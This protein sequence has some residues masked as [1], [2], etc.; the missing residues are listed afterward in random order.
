MAT[1][2]GNTLCVWDT[3]SGRARQMN[4]QDDDLEGTFAPTWKAEKPLFSACNHQKAIT[5][6]TYNSSGSRLLT[7]ALDQFVKVYSTT[8]YAVV[9]SFPYPAPVQAVALSPDDRDLVVG[10]ADGKV[11]INARPIGA[12]RAAPK[13][14]LFES[15]GGALF[16]IPPQHKWRRSIN[17]H[18]DENDIKLEGKHSKRME[19]YDYHFRKF[20]YHKALDQALNYHKRNENDPDEDSRLAVL[21]VLEELF[22]RNGLRIALH[23]RTD[24]SLLPILKFIDLHI[25]DPRSCSLLVSVLEVIIEIYAGVIKQS[26]KVELLMQS[27]LNKVRK[28]VAHLQQMAMVDGMLDCMR[29]ACEAQSARR[30]QLQEAD[31]GTETES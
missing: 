6:L 21:S 12:Q 18:A 27:C 29:I 10:M 28:H 23:G 5:S 17:T 20:A 9:H 14:D 31:A 3:V 22:R 13:D 25:L 4:G 15:H 8:S 11:T 2:A 24:A 1:A 26:V 30:Q 7:G 19:G 16:E